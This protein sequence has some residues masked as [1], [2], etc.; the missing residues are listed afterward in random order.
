[1]IHYTR[2]TSHRITNRAEIDAARAAGASIIER[3]K[4]QT[5]VSYYIAF[6]SQP[7]RY[8]WIARAYHRW[9]MFSWR[10]YRP[11]EKPLAAWHKRRCN[12]D[13]TTVYEQPD[14]K[15][16]ASKICFYI[17][18]TN[19]Q[20]LRCEH[21]HRKHYTHLTKITVDKNIYDALSKRDKF[22]EDTS[23]G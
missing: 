23:Y 18:L 2:G 9:D 7:W 17:P 6:Y 3:P 19:R 4:V 21:L 11:L 22:D 8:Y 13:C 1:M 20:D 14:L 16:G 10:I 5:D 15:T 12:D